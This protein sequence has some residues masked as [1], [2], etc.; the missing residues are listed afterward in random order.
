MNPGW[1]ERAAR[2]AGIGVTVGVAVF[3]APPL[4]GF[5]TAGVAAGSIAAGIQSA[6]YGAAIP[7]GGWFATMQSIGATATLVPALVAGGGAA[8]VAGVVVGAEGNNGD[9]N[10]GDNAGNGGDDDPAGDSDS[11]DD[12]EGYGPGARS[13]PPHYEDKLQQAMSTVGEDGTSGLGMEKPRKHRGVV[14]KPQ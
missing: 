8:G 9:G 14:A 1:R 2:I 3:V 5:T 6:V 11:D 12:S 10:G 13:P 7:A 4:L